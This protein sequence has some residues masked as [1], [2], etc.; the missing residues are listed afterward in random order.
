MENSIVPSDLKVAD[1]T[2]PKF[3]KEN[4]DLKR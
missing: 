3:Q 4:K 1:V 2:D